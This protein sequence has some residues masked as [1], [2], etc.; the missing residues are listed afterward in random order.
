MIHV[1]HKTLADP[2]LVAGF[3][4]RTSNPVELSGQGQIRGLWQRFF[5]EDL[6]AQIP[7]RTSA[8]FYVVYS[9]YASDE[10]GEY[11]YL[12]GAP[13]SSIENLP[14]GITFAGI[15]TGEYAVVTTEKGP[16]ESVMQSAWREIWSMPVAELGGKRAFLTDY[17]VYDERASDPASAQVEIH[18]GLEP[19]VS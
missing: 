13:V 5:A 19:E 2:I 17:E 12:L 9:N 3:Q 7:N 4:V 10:Y 16:V 11:D 6:A 1:R 8:N 14:E 18:L 15:A